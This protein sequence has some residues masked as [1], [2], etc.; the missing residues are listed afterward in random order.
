M[1]H[2][3][4]VQNL[5][6]ALGG[7]SVHHL[8]R[9]GIRAASERNPLPLVLEP[10]THAALAKFVTVERP[11]DIADAALHARV[12]QLGQEARA[13][14]HVSPHPVSALYVAIYWIFQPTDAP[15]GPLL[16]TDPNL[17]RGWHLKPADFAATEEIERFAA[18]TDEWGG[19]PGLVIPSVKDAQSG[20]EALFAVMA[21]GEGV[22]GDQESSHFES[23]LQVLDA[24]EANQVSTFGLCRTPRIDDQPP[25]EDTQAT[26]LTNP[27][28]DAWGR[29]LNVR[30]THL[31]LSIAH[32]I[33]R[34]IEDADRGTL[35][36]AAR[37]MMRP[38]LAGI[39]RLLGRLDA[40]VAGGA[41]AG[42][43]FGLLDESLPSDAG[44]YWARH[45]ALLAAEA[46]CVARIR[47]RPEHASDA[48]GRLLLQQL[49]AN[50]QPL[51][52][53]VAA[54]QQ[55]GGLMQYAIYPPIG[56]ARIGNSPTEFFIGPERR[57]S[58]GTQVDGTG[59]E[60]EVTDFKDAAFRVK[61]QAARFTIFEIPDDGLPRPAQFPAGTTIE[62]T[63]RMV[64]KKDAIARPGNPPAAPMKPA[65]K[66]GREDRI[67]DSQRQTIS[68]PSAGPV[69]LS[70]TYRQT[71]VALGQ[72]RSDAAQRLLVI[73]GPGTS[74]SPTNAPIGGSFYNNPDWYDDVA[75]G[76]VTAKVTLPAGPSPVIAPAWVVVG[77]PDF[78][79]ASAGVVTLY[80]VLLQV[81]L[82]H[83]GTP[84][85]AQPFFVDHIRP[86]IERARNLRFVNN[87][88]TWPLISG[89][90]DRLA[91]P[92]A[93]SKPLREETAL[94][95]RSVED[96]LHDFQLQ[97]WQ[98]DYLDKWVAGSFNPG[99]AP[100]PG[101]A[102][103]MTRAVLDG[104][105]GQGFFPGIEAGIIVTDPSLYVAPFDF[106]FDPAKVE[107]GDIT[108]LMA[109]PWQADF[110]KC[111]GA[112]WPS[113]RPDVAPQ[114]NG[115]RPPWLRPSM[116][117]KR[118]VADVMRLGVVTPAKDQ[119][120]NDIGV[121]RG[122]DPQL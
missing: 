80:D 47:V 100:D 9:D 81:A 78:S 85:P 111:S 75:D 101:A 41:K 44:G 87:F 65:I 16:L 109:L 91:D 86:L 15:F 14:A 84:L 63:V 20:C 102:A 103:T 110:L 8:G 106:R 32:A 51:V 13:A 116:N 57:G 35:I 59:A 97:G 66:P 52:D 83:G 5:L 38:S 98:R 10:I 119:Q 30:Y 50:D 7:T 118:L 1:G 42:P 46:E 3:L 27:Y 2:L 28:A 45:R 53:L 90:F 18:G 69:A 73:G 22:P 121:E 29:L 55:P 36:E 115:A 79:P 93:G 67:I 11:A 113:Q 25:S 104:A 64:N 72:L 96:Q 74:A 37:L 95:V 70:G 34:P 26:V 54:H 24:F 61:P 108:A 12:E 43:P 99:A 88:A 112:W 39:I 49:A 19:H 94:L 21:Q 82:D 68:G 117:H 17:R 33:S 107:P 105:V 76:P 114:D 77:P 71:N 48:A 56:L 23:F 31:V 89:D 58:R 4:C 120:G 92:S 60:G 122:R 62:W 40:G 6:L